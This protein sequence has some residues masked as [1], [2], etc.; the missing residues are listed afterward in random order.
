MKKF[1]VWRLMAAA[2]LA[3]G[4]VMAACSSHKNPDTT[5]QPALGESTAPVP[6]DPQAATAPDN[7]GDDLRTAQAEP[8]AARDAGVTSPTGTM[9]DGGI[10]ATGGMGDGGMAAPRN[11]NQNPT[12]PPSPTT[13]PSSTSPTAPGQP[14]NPGTPPSPPT[15]TNPSTPPPTGGTTPPGGSPGGTPH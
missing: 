1:P 10:G 2:V 14:T 8:T 7:N 13:P 5:P 15:P 6:A 3:G 9:R 4:A 11:N 12:R